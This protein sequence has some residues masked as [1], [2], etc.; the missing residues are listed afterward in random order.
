MKG[1]LENTAQECNDHE[2]ELES[3]KREVGQLAL[4]NRRLNQELVAS[5]EKL[6]WKE[7]DNDQVNESFKILKKQEEANLKKEQEKTKILEEKRAEADRLEG[8]N[9]SLLLERGEK[10]KILKKMEKRKIY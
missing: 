10:I 4:E 1:Q 9:K 7:A 6:K 8:L 2:N 3:K 5:Q